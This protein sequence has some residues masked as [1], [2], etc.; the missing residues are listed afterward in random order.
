MQPTVELA[1]RNSRR[2]IDP[3]IEESAA[4]QDKVDPGALATPANAVLSKEFAGGFEGR[5]GRDR[6]WCRHSGTPA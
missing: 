6:G 2:R 4:L 1:K 3:L 5:A